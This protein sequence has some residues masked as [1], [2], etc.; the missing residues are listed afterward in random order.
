MRG[1]AVLGQKTSNLSIIV[2]CLI[3]CNNTALEDGAEVPSLRDGE[4][5]KDEPSVESE[6]LTVME[7]LCS[8]DHVNINAVAILQSATSFRTVSDINTAVLMRRKRLAIDNE[9]E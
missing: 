1:R 4:L 6:I 5:V 8:K 2:S 7:Y 3:S 9:R